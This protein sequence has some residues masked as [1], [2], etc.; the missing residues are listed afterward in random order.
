MAIL[1]RSDPD[2]YKYLVHLHR[3]STSDQDILH[4]S[5]QALL[6]VGCGDG[7][8]RD[9]CGHLQRGRVESAERQGD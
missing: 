9:G 8:E 5:E 6:D 3:S 7:R 2:I 1:S 4:N